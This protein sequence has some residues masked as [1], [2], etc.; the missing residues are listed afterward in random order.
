MD[1]IVRTFVV[2]GF[3]LQALALVPFTMRNAHNQH[4]T[5]TFRNFV[6]IL[7]VV[8]FAVALVLHLVGK[9]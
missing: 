9:S 2:I 1:D 6:Q 3:L 8:A 7:A 4:D 5:A